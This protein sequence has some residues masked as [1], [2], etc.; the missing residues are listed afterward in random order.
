MK[1][2]FYEEDVIESTRLENIFNKED[3][4][5][6]HWNIC[7]QATDFQ[8]HFK[9]LSPHVVVFRYKNEENEMILKIN[10]VVKKKFPH[11]LRYVMM[12]E[13][14]QSALMSTLSPPW[15]THGVILLPFQLNL[16]N[17]ILEGKKRSLK[18]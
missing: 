15:E 16:F 17:Y 11:I 8:K 3:K 12:K 5:I 13:S 10:D 1:I 4:T 18:K 14:Q 9:Q 7:S 6:L 2:L